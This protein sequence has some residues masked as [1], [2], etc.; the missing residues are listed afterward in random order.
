[1]SAE[2]TVDNDYMIGEMVS[3]DEALATVV[4]LH[5]ARSPRANRRRTKRQMIRQIRPK[6]PTAVKT[7]PWYQPFKKQVTRRASRHPD[8]RLLLRD[9]ASQID[10]QQA[11]DPHDEGFANAATTVATDGKGPGESDLFLDPSADPDE[12]LAVVF[13]PVDD[14]ATVLEDDPED[15]LLPELF[16]DPEPNVLLELPFGFHVVEGGGCF[17]RRD[18]LERLQRAAETEPDWGDPER[19]DDGRYEP[20]H[21]IVRT[22]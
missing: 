18:K 13:V 7:T 2:A 3:R 20:V 5:K 10:V 21:L 14:R 17:S 6:D 8:G 12:Q 22:R 1:M 9:R 15:D 11:L 4:P 19:W 16:G